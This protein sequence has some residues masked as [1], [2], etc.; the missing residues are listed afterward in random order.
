MYHYLF[1]KKWKVVLFVI[2]LCIA[3]ILGTGFALV[4]SSFVDSVAKGQ[5]FVI[6][7]LIQSIIYVSCCASFEAVYM[8][9]KNSI[10]KD[11]RVQLKTDIFTA[12]MKKS[13]KNFE[14]SN[15]AEYLNE[16]NHNFTL[17]QEIYF[18]NLLS[19][20]SCFIMFVIAS[21]VCIYLEPMMLLVM[22]G[23]AVITLFSTKLTTTSL[24]KSSND[25]TEASEQYL[26]EIKD[27]FQGYHVIRSFGVLNLILNRHKKINSAMEE[28][29]LN[30]LN[31]KVYCMFIGELVGL[32]STVFVMGIAAY[33]A[34]KGVFSAGLVIAFGHLIGQVVSPITQI[35]QL[36]ANYRASKPLTKRFL[37]ILE[38][39]QDEE[40]KTKETFDTEISIKNLSFSY[41]GTRN[42]LCG[43]NAMLKKGKRYAIVG[44][45]GVGKS[46]L[47][48]LLTGIYKEYEGMLCIDGIEFRELNDTSIQKLVGIVTQD[49]FLFNNTLY[50]NIT[51][52]RDNFSEE[53]VQMAIAKAGLTEFVKRLSNGIHT[54]ISE[55][56]QNLSGGEK[57]RIG[58]A[59]ALLNR[60]P[61]LLLDE[62]TAN[63]DEKNAKEIE[64]YIL[65][66]PNITIIMITHK[67]E[68][69]LL[70]RFDEVI[71]I[72]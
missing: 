31:S 16:L 21:F 47:F 35:P 30:F 28:A 60:N 58:L 11:A 64:N 44:E 24:E 51:M 62:P 34:S 63:L 57:Q 38:K 68:K 65:K 54:I 29:N 37:N 69:E 7:L 19:I 4:M 23:L 48:R 10:C 53:E 18:N 14:E 22:I 39:E 42:L 12:I 50:Q 2:C 15:S 17:Y 46:T 9:M 43:L 70:N 26:T 67:T 66:I 6:T 13:V 56:G 5:N 40:G 36:M 27:D 52:F 59:R 45:S 1:L 41:D 71:H 72:K 32:L 8:L 49:T 33:Y 3:Q 61:I 25:V 55:N 20:P